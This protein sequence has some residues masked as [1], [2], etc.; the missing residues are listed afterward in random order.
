MTANDTL[1]GGAGNDTL[2]G[3]NN[4]DLVKGGAGADSLLGG[5]GDDTLDGGTENDT[6]DGG[7]GNDTIYGAAGADSIR[8]AAGND[9]LY[10]DSNAT[11][12]VDLSDSTG[13]SYSGGGT[14]TPP[15]NGGETTL[16]ILP[17]AS[18]SA[19]NSISHD[20]TGT[21]WASGT[22]YV[23][24]LDATTQAQSGTTGLRGTGGDSFV[25]NITVG[26]VIVATGT[27]TTGSQTNSFQHYTLTLTGTGNIPTDPSATP[28]I[29]IISNKLTSAATPNSNNID[30]DNVVVTALDGTPTA[31]QN[32]TMDGGVGDDTLYGQA[33]NDSL[34]GG[35]GN[36]QLYGGTGNDTLYGGDDNDLI[37][38]GLDDDLIYGGL[39]A[40][41][42]QGG[43][44]DDT[45]YGDNGNDQ[46]QAGPGADSVFGGAGADYV[47][48]DVG[49]DYIDGGAD[50]DTLLSGDGNDTVLGNDGDDSI[51]AGAG[52]DSVTGG[53]GNDSIDAGAGDDTVWGLTGNDTIYGAD[54]ADLIYGDDNTNLFGGADSL[55]GG[56]GNDTIYGGGANDTIDGG[57]G[58]DV[59]TGGLGNDRFVGIT[60][61]DV[62]DGSEDPGDTDTDVLDLFASGFTW[63]TT[64]I[65][66]STPNHEN[67]TVYFLDGNGNQIG[68]MTFSNI[69]SIIPCFTPGTL[70]D[71]LRGPTAIEEI[72]RGDLVL[73]RD[74]GYQPV[75]W[76]GRRDLSV[77]DLVVNPRLC[78][79]RVRAGALGPGMPARDMLLS[80]QHRILVTSAQ[81]ELLTGESEVL[82]AARYFVDRPGFERAGPCT[83]GYIHLMFDE[84]EI[85]RSD[86]IWS[87]SF[88]PGR[89]TVDA[90]GR[91]QR[92]ELLALF[93]ELAMQS[94][95]TAYE[96]ARM[97]V[98]A[99]EAR[100]I[101]AMSA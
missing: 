63:T 3:G 73:T 68:S 7:D 81:A 20:L 91:E 89:A 96:P 70:I 47:D 59:M 5:A 42:L 32:D 50:N 49:N 44:G 88:Q 37:D 39:G 74:H 85:V 11:Q 58:S 28:K 72:R 38:G 27:A 94:G 52:N 41:T 64:N 83:V 43:Q 34:L 98:Q 77:A 99:H 29:Q 92:D 46:I 4:N 12:S 19:L 57:A 87:E 84:H 16:Y 55:F 18:S 78:P 17:S 62:V 25:V 97:S 31:S 86:G 13:W 71:T 8:G 45:I 95:I 82:A 40:D 21:T 26:G 14:F 67:G 90:L 54:G 79:V 23:V 48:G 6:I 66:Y 9:V 100:L 35:A 80:P 61:G 60:A 76:I 24:D 51:N 33:G 93:P 22:S 10:G 101:L 2:D 65:V 15:Y 30:L 36:D 56:A 1:S 75:R 53:T 69:E